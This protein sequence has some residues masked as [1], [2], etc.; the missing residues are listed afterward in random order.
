M[1]QFETHEF[2]VPLCRPEWTS[3]LRV[4]LFYRKKLLNVKKCKINNVEYYVH[5]LYVVINITWFKSLG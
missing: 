4:T 5:K 2:R 1:K 3:V